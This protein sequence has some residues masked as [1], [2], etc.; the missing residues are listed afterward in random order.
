MHSISTWQAPN[1]QQLSKF[2]FMA[3]HFYKHLLCWTLLADI[4]EALFHEAAVWVMQDPP[5]A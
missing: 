4:S 3:H 5:S 2:D 1:T